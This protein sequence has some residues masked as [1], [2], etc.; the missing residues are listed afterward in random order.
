MRF[1]LTYPPLEILLEPKKGE[2]IKAYN[3]EIDPYNDTA[4]ILIDHLTK[5]TFDAFE[6]GIRPSDLYNNSFRSKWN[7][8]SSLFF[9][10][11]V[12]TSIGSSS[13]SSGGY[14]RK[15]RIFQRG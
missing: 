12:L 6:A 14:V 7:L 8:A 5:V 2:A 9:T 10:T 1:F 11:T 15:K 3:V 13:I 4:I